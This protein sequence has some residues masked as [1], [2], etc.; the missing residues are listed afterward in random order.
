[1]QTLSLHTHPQRNELSTASLERLILGCCVFDAYEGPSA[2]SY[3]YLN[4]EELLWRAI[5]EVVG[6]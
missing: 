5:S 3:G 2:G 4:V 1:M 6:D